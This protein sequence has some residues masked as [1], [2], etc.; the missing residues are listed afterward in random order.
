MANSNVVR[1]AIAGYVQTNQYLKLPVQ[2]LANTTLNEKLNIAANLTLTDSDIVGVSC[3]V[4]G[5]G[6]HGFT[7]GAN[8]L[9]KWDARLHK[10]QHNALFNQVPFV[11]RLPDQDL[12]PTE[13]LKYR[14]RTMVSYG[15]Q[16]YVAYFARVLDL[17]N[18][19]VALELRTVSNGV[20]TATPYTPTIED[21]NP[22]PDTLTTGQVLT[23]TGD[24]VASTAKVPFTMSPSEV[25]DFVNAMKIITGE[26]GYAIISEMGTVAGVDRTISNTIAGAVQ[27]YPELIGAMIT[28]HIP[29]AWVMEYQTDGITLTVDVGNVEPLLEVTPV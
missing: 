29:T 14:L 12:T 23:A 7:I 18:T 28:S 27:N 20:T 3:V 26:D 22:V 11:L 8:G 6:G 1:T 4:I 24:Y 10:P 21:L 5:N 25:A 15:G 16:D 17:S 2:Q 19:Q 13:R 9:V